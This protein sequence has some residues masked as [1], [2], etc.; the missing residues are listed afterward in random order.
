VTASRPTR[1]GEPMRVAVLGLVVGSIAAL[2]VISSASSPSTPSPAAQ[3]AATITL[4]AESSAM[5]C[6]GLNTHTGELSSQVAIADLSASP[7]SVEVTTTNQ[8]GRHS[9]REVSV[10][11]GHVVHLDPNRLLAG[12][13]EAVSVL[14]IGGGVTASEALGGQNGTAV[15][16]CVTQAAPSW[17]LTGGSTEPGESFQVSVYN[18]YASRADV[19]ASLA[20]P[21]TS[22]YDAP[23]AYQGFVLGPYELAVLSIHKVR[24]NESPISVYV[25][26]NSGDV[27]VYGVGRATLGAKSISVVPGTP[28]PSTDWLLPLVHTATGITTTLLLANP[29]TTPVT[30][31]LRVGNDFGCGASCPA[32]YTTSIAPGATTQV[33]VAALSGGR[34]TAVTAGV[35]VLAASPGVVVTQRVATYTSQGQMAPLYDPD[36]VDADHLVLLNPLASGFDELGIV[37]PTATTLSVAL[38]TVGPSGVRSLRSITV[39]ARSSVIVG[40]GDLRGVVDGVL[41]LEAAGPISAEAEVHG[42]IAGSSLLAAVP[43]G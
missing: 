14:S 41:E 10:R 33:N 22:G 28:S 11:P 32:P 21:S 18:P 5:F 15:A 37:N 6:A 3:P 12:S 38:L 4:D 8:A 25:K 26:A 13:T 31:S 17:W 16:P 36:L 34:P 20:T 7:R 1:R 30:A 39:H 43:A 9:L 35:E 40:R 2:G 19:T 42:A 27:V 24:P 23:E 29:S